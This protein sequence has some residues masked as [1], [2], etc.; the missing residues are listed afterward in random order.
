MLALLLDVGRAKTISRS[1][2]IC[3]TTAHR[4][5]LC[6]EKYNL[7]LI[8]ML[9]ITFKIINKHILAKNVGFNP[10]E[11]INEVKATRFASGF[12]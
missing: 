9:Y 1:S 4:P 8:L 6:F 10:R 2:L 7:L 5:I 11:R 3:T 12:D